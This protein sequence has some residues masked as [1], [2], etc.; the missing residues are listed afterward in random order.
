MPEHR[1]RGGISRWYGLW[2]ACIAFGFTLLGIRNY[3]AGASISNIALH[4]V[5]AAGFAL[6]AY[7]EYRRRKTAGSM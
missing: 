7:V 5:I 1:R 2:Y 6:L 4:G 3:L